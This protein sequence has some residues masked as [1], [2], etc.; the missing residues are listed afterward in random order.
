MNGFNQS[1]DR[2]SNQM[3][4]E[5]SDTMMHS[6]RGFHKYNDGSSD[7]WMNGHQSE[8]GWMDLDMEEDIM[9]IGTLDISSFIC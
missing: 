2:A 9:D 8:G 1:T 7:R 4:N 6:D 3:N 5:S